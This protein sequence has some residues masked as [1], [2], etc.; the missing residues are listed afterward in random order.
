LTAK[1]DWKKN[2]QADDEHAS[3]VM[4]STQVMNGKSKRQRRP[5]YNVTIL[6]M[7]TDGHLFD[8]RRMK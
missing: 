6:V 8:L 4:R 2:T 5:N 3:N 7:R 1:T